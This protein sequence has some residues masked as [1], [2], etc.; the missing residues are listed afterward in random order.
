MLPATEEDEQRVRD[1]MEGQA[2][3]LTV[4][5]VQKVYEENIV[6]HIHAVWDVHTNK[7]RWCVMT[8]PM[9]LYSQEQFPNMDYAVTFHVGLCIRIPRSE[10]QR[11]TDLP[12]EPF[13]GV[14]NELSDA[15]DRLLTAKNVADYKAIGVRC[16]ETLLAFA[17]VA[18]EV[19]PW[20]STEEKPKRADF[21]TWVDHI[22]T[23]ILQGP[24]HEHRRHLFKSMLDG[25]WKFDNWLTHSKS[26]HIRDAECA[27]EVTG[28]AT[29][30]CMSAIIHH[31]RVCQINA[32]SV[33]L[34]ICRQSEA[35]TRP[36][37]DGYSNARPAMT[38]IGSVKRWRSGN[39]PRKNE[40]HP[41][42][43]ALSPI[44]RSGN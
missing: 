23:V 17:D 1:Y 22:C 3:D 39:I 32:R 20:T 2:Q 24:A 27:I 25:A 5:F 37:Q 28:M 4:T 7:D 10:K 16:R 38:V 43:S 9:N 8:N 6:N 33:T 40:S 12:V 15:Q 21:K 31:I 44:R 18:Q 11:A 19:L 26:S 13:A 41:K 42:A 29:Q 36:C 14:Y 34:R 30:L 35:R